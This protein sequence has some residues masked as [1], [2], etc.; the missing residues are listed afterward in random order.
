MEE[1]VRQVGELI[2]YGLMRIEL[3]AAGDDRGVAVL[4]AVNIAPREIVS[5]KGVDAV[6]VS[7]WLPPHCDLLGDDALRH[8]RECIELRLVTKKVNS[9]AP[10]GSS[11]PI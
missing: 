10:R 11:T 4:H 9:Q 6:I 7:G 8:C 5:D 1:L 2:G 3:S